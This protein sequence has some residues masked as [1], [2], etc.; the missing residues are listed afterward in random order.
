[1]GR[2]DRRG[3][4]PDPMFGVAIPN[5]PFLDAGRKV[6]RKPKGSYRHDEQRCLDSRSLELAVRKPQ[7]TV[8]RNRQKQSESPGEP[9]Q[10]PFW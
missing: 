2:V 10:H 9:E 7:S 4:T 5:V 1:M 6:V 8:T 3:Q